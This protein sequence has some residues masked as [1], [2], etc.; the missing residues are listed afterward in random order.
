[1]SFGTDVIFDDV[2][3]A[4]DD[5]ERVAL[6]G[7][8]GIGKTTLF[9]ILIG[10][11]EADAGK[12]ALRN[13]ARLSHLSQ[14]THLDPGATPREIVGEAV[15]PL[16]EA[17]AAYE[18]LSAEIE[19][20]DDLDAAIRRQDEMRQRIESL[21]GWDWERRVDEVLARLG[22]AEHLDA[23]IRYLSGGQRRRVAL[24]GVLI[25]SPDLLLMDEPTNHL[26]PDTV[27]WLE[28]WLRQFS[29]A[30]LL[31]T[32]D[33]YFLE[34]VAERIIEVA[35]DGLHSH[36]GTY[37]E[38]VDRKEHRAEV[39]RKTKQRKQK[40]LDDELDW[41]DRGVKARGR[42]SKDRHKEIELAKKQQR[43]LDER[44]VDIPISN[45]PSMGAHVLSA[46]G[47]YKS[48][49][50]RQVLEDVSI[51]IVPGDKL[52]ILGPN[53]CGKSTLLDILMGRERLNAGVVEKSEETKIGYL[54]QSD[55]T[56][57]P[58]KSVFD[59]FSESDYVW[60]GDTRYHKRKYLERFLFGKKLLKT[61]VKMLSGGQLRRLR[62]ARVI[63]Q[64]ANLLILDEPTN[65][66]DIESLRALEEALVD[67]KGC[68]VVVSHDR[69]FLNRVCNSIC[70]F[71]DGDLVRY[72][73]DYD[74]YREQRDQKLEARRASPTALPTDEK[75]AEDD[76]LDEEPEN[77]QNK[78]LS[79]KEKR[80]LEELEH[81]IMEAEAQKDALEAELADPDLYA[82]RSD[83][84]A[85]LNTKLRD[86]TARLEGL[87]GEWE[88]LEMRRG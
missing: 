54:S 87:Y 10:R 11:Y 46:R 57:D 42:A 85:E 45:G 40:L 80:R 61:P 82:N 8:N 84:I 24:A 53:G 22:L 15:R 16:R 49:G 65:D 43:L 19:H 37:E 20:A 30:L 60:I 38:F 73:G 69:Y 77:E 9:R 28:G 48:Y 17:I 3:F 18:K 71:E 35:P 21:G 58:D 33:R 81:E 83:E 76:E 31:I 23:K 70:A 7:P 27:E 44:Q 86:V 66:L 52:G 79:W 51:S 50:D 32:H 39:R 25:E 68:I 75:E 59:A 55:M 26:D 29:G 13:G 41:L 74:D 1:M 36:P 88:G 34:Q 5:G 6:M 67:Y 63:A 12:I 47:I 78:K 14:E 62:L 72:Y 64:N 4:V 2:D 56:M